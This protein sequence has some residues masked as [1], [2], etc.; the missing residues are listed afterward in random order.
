N[1]N[2]KS[3]SNQSI[4][5]SAIDSILDE[6]SED[7]TKTQKQY[8]TSKDKHTQDDKQQDTKQNNTKKQDVNPQL[9]TQ[10]ELKHKTKP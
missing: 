6:Y 9:P 2:D 10:D 4:S 1:K 5:D 3:S 7:A 8:Q